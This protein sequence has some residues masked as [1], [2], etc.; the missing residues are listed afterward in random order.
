MINSI[1]KVV[2]IKGDSREFTKSWNIL[3]FPL[4]IFSFVFAIQNVQIT[5][6]HDL[7]IIQLCQIQ[8][9]T[10]EVKHSALRKWLMHL[11]VGL[12]LI[13]QI[14][15]WSS[16]FL[17][18]FFVVEELALCCFLFTAENTPIAFIL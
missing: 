12:D 17:Y 3:I 16:T 4:F 7:T 11:V 2:K 6:G 15:A 10:N 9:S 1:I 18:Q 14:K 5:Y 8:S 13:H